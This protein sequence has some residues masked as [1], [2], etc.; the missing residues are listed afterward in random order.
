MGVGGKVSRY[1]AGGV[2]FW[3]CLFDTA[4][5]KTIETRKVARKW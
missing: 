5:T 3:G 2:A 1:L 4:E